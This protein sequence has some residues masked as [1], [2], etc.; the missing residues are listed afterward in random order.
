MFPT[1]DVPPQHA[2]TVGARKVRRAKEENATRRSSTS[3]SQSSG[4]ANSIAAN[5]KRQDASSSSISKSG[6]KSGFSSWFSKSSKKGVQEISPL[7]TTNNTPSPKEV[8]GEPK[9]DVELDQGPT[10]PTAPLDVQDH[11]FPRPPSQQ[12]EKQT[13]PLQPQRFPPPLSPL[14]SPPP[15]GGLPSTPSSGLLSPV[16]IPGMCYS[17]QLLP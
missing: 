2:E 9:P 14:P 10:P 17:P 8:T 1:F 3:T 5:S 16:N 11:V 6:E 13:R 12:C 4:S 15:T 7:S